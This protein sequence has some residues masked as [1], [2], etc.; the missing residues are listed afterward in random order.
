[1]GAGHIEWSMLFEAG[2]RLRNAQQA[3]EALPERADCLEAASQPL[4]HTQK[5]SVAAW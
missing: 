1:M 5:Y 3:V 2:R 4:K